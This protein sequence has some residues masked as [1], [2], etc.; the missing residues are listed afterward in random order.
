MPSEPPSLV[1]EHSKFFSHARSF[2]FFSLL[3]IWKK[4]SKPSETAYSELVLMLE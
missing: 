2:K 1:L 3:N 4:K